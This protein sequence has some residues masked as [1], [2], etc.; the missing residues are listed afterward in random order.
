MSRFTKK[1][2]IFSV[3]FLS[4]IALLRYSNILAFDNGESLMIDSVDM[5]EEEKVIQPGEGHAS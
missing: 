4:T 3:I 2:I 1:I 5:T